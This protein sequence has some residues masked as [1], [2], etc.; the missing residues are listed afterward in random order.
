M[1]RVHQSVYTLSTICIH[2]RQLYFRGIL[3]SISLAL[4]LLTLYESSTARTMKVIKELGYSL[5]RG[6]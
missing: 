4:C 1:Q 5:P 3:Q 2:T 6:F